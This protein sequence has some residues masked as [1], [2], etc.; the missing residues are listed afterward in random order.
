MQSVSPSFH[1]WQNQL[2]GG[3]RR[4]PRQ[5]RK[6]GGFKVNDWVFHQ[7]KQPAT[8]SRDAPSRF[9]RAM[10]PC[11]YAACLPVRHLSTE[12][13]DYLF[14][15]L[16][17]MHLSLPSS[18]LP[19]HLIT[20]VFCCTIPL[21]VIVLYCITLGCTVPVLHYCILLC[22]IVLLHCMVLYCVVLNS[23]VLYCI[24]VLYCAV[25]YYC[26]VWCCIVLY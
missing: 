26:I 14:T 17:Y 10:L 2:E 22:C 20:S 18:I 6:L 19:V 16:L 25:L 12:L 5:S 23:A 4:L 7:L 11:G 15:S 24:I 9:G 8:S 13:Y 21:Y 1:L 3:V